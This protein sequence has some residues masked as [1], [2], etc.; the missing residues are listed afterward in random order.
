MGR[1]KTGGKVAKLGPA[2]GAL[3]AARTSGVPSREEVEE[4]GGVEDVEDV[5]DVMGIYI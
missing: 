4:V 3:C 5:D 2:P 1:T